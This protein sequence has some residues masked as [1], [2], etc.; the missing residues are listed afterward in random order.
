[1]YEIITTVLKR[2]DDSAIN[3]GY[4]LVYQCLRTITKI[5][6]SQEL[7][8][9]A[10]LTISRF[11]ASA[12]KNLKYMGI[13]GLIQIVRIDPKYTLDY[14]NMVVDCLEDADDT[15]KIKTLELLFKMTNKM[16][17]EPI[18]D[19]LL[20]FLKDAPVESASRKDL[21]VK[22]NELGEKFAP[23][24][25]WY[26]RTMNKL[27]EM[28]GDL[29][30][31]NLTNKF[32]QSIGEYEK[33]EDG[34]TFRENTI[35]IYLKVL[36]K[37]PNIP[38][39]LMQVIAW[40][41][42]E[43]GPDIPDREK[44][45][46]IVEELCIQAYNGYENQNTV[47]LIVQALGKIHHAQGYASNPPIE[48]V[49][50]DF[51]TSKFIL[52]QEACI[53]YRTLVDLRHQLPNEGRDLFKGTPLNEE[54][55]NALGLDLDLSFLS[56]FVREQS[57]KGLPAYDES[58]SVIFGNAASSAASSHLNFKAYE[59][60]APK[61]ATIN[62]PYGVSMTDQQPKETLQNNP[63]FNMPGQI[64]TN[65]STQLKVNSYK[66]VWGTQAQEQA[67]AE[68][69]KTGDTSHYNANS[70]QNKIAESQSY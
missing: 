45:E 17:V 35:K 10:T 26:I 13:V 38:E 56:G 39:S 16:N 28:G 9:L 60:E 12:S 3:V 18:V 7:L 66:Q 5:Y 46:Q 68:Q 52:V 33:Q 8:D 34:D 19:K 27:F 14:Q 15:L 37:N 24:K 6:P 57:G 61:I 25:N 31:Q 69:Q 65:T 70:M 50:S 53:E 42:G 23:N 44:I 41:M 40:I 54:Q 62:Q 59:Q 36:K 43:Y 29:V 32:I 22:I 63:V 2:S 64:A 55:T 48:S 21:V 58:R 20:A 30:T 49:M 4:A 47:A 51:L 1:M 67:P 11:L